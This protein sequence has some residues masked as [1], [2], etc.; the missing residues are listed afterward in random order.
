MNFIKKLGLFI[1]MILMV[2]TGAALIVLSLRVVSINTW[3]VC[4]ESVYSSFNLQIA[5]SAVGA[6]FIAIGIIVPRRAS[7]KLGGRNK[8]ITF[9]NPDGEVTVSLS[10]IEGYVR[11][12]AKDI[13]GIEDVRSN[14]KVSKKKGITVIS[15]VSISAGTNIPEATESI[16]VVV[17]SKI[18][19]ML[20]VEEPVNVTMH[21]TK[22]MKDAQSDEA[23]PQ[24][25]D[26]QGVPFREME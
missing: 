20:G 14:V 3:S 22:I 5:I 10:A 19:E 13:P 6:I 2:A 8:L 17:K 24:E 7:R 23:D 25:E 11:K 16:Q 15:D 12:V 9:Q 1:Y 26:V 4:L 21:I 18:Q